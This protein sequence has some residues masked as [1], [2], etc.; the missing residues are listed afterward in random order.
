MAGVVVDDLT[1]F[2][3]LRHT[4][5]RFYADPEPPGLYLV[6]T[7]RGSDWPEDEVENR[8]N[9]TLTPR[10]QAGRSP[11]TQ[12]RA[13]IGDVAGANETQSLDPNAPGCER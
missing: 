9:G 11:P 5:W 7:L 8:L 3:E 4:F 1:P 10:S 6:H 13:L 12:K 2:C